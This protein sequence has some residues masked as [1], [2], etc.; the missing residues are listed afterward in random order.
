[1]LKF[2]SLRQKFEFEVFEKIEPTVRKKRLKRFKK[3]GERQFDI[4]AP[5]RKFKAHA[6]RHRQA[7]VWREIVE[8]KLREVRVREQQIELLR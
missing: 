3:F 7:L 2:H 6:A 4:F 1:M 8:T 5:L